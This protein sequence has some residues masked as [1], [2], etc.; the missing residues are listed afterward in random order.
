MSLKT[1]MTLKIL[2]PLKALKAFIPLSLK[3]IDK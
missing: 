1:Q 2:M 3:Q